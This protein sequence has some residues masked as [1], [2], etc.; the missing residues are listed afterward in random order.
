VSKAT[1]FSVLLLVALSGGA[2]AADR[3]N[4]ID[5][6]TD[7]ATLKGRTLELEGFFSPSRKATAFWLDRSVI[8]TRFSSTSPRWSEI[9]GDK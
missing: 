8:S 2:W 4:I 3:M 7:K 9:S 6:K 5:F 1:S